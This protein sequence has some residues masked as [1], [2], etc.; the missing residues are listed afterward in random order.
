MGLLLGTR[1]SLEE[2]GKALS[3]A[4]LRGT[5]FL[6]AGH[7]DAKG[8]DESNLALSQ[9]RAEAVKRFLVQTHHVDEG[10]LSVIDRGGPKADLSCKQKAV[11]AKALAL[12]SLRETIDGDLAVLPVPG[13][14]PGKSTIWARNLYPRG[15]RY[16][17]QN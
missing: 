12:K 13:S 7:T 2:L 9:R 17:C 11:W 3:D 1:P 5:N 4:K 15:R 10:R 6:I 14:P 16:S 8:S